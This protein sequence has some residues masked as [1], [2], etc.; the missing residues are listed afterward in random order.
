MYIICPKCNTNFVITENQIG[1]TGRK[2]RCSKCKH[3]W[4]AKQTNKNNHSSKKENIIPTKNESKPITPETRFYDGN[5][6]LLPTI[7]KDR[8]NQDAKLCFY[9]W[10]ITLLVI[11]MIISL[12]VINFGHF[13]FSQDFIVKEVDARSIDN[14]KTK[15]EFTIVN[16][17]TRTLNL[18]IIRYRF[19]DKNNKIITRKLVENK[20]AKLEPKESITIYKEFEIKAVN[21]DVTLGS[22]LD[23]IMRY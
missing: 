2:V 5:A 1:K 17:T 13:R 15:I 16:N 7:I 20:I 12:D 11:V 6:R 19:F 3:I 8:N 4:I 23:F 14:N 9:K 18:P 10:A 22:K 21:L